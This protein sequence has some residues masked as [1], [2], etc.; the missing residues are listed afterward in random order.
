MVVEFAVE[1]VIGAIHFLSSGIWRS[2][3][4]LVKD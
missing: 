2:E 4:F 3:D 1:K